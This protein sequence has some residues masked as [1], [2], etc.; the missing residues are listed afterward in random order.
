ML[1]LSLL[2]NNIT[3]IIVAG[4]K[5]RLGRRPKHSGHIEE[6]TGIY[7]EGNDYNINIT[8]CVRLNLAWLPQVN[9]NDMF[10]KGSRA[11]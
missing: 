2:Q 5:N 8:N 11:Y 7:T 1:C 9:G 3:L 10:S 4:S 6:A